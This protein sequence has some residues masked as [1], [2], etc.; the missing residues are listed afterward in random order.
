VALECDGDRYHGVDQIPEDMARQSV[1]ERAGWK[2][3]R[4]RG[5][6]HYRDPDA[7]MKWVFTELERL[8]V[9]PAR[10]RDAEHRDGSAEFHDATMQRAWEIMRQQEWTDD[11]SLSRSVAS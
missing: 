2:F 7:T 3:V 5:T 6:R 9:R 11:R 1:L 8:N 4:V 10:D